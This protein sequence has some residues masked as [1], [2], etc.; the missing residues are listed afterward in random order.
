MRRVQRSSAAAVLLAAAILVGHASLPR[1]ADAQFGSLFS[2]LNL[3]DQRQEAELA[4]R[5]A[6]E[7]ESQKPLLRDPEVQ[8]YIVEIGDRLIR[9]LRRPE[10]RYRFRV[11]ADR[12]VNAFG[13][14]GGFI[15]V[16]AGLIATADTEGEVVAVLAHEIGH[17][18]QR[19]V[20]KQ[21]S[22]QTVFQNLARLAIGQNAGQWINLAAGLGVTTGQAY[23][24]RE[25]EREADSVMVS[26]M[27]AAGYDPREA[28]AMFAKLRSIQ[29]SNPNLVSSI[30]SSHPPTSERSENVRRE[31]AK[32]SR[33]R[34]LTRDS[35]AF[36]NIRARIVAAMGRRR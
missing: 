9:S 12:A 35:R 16:N 2:N 17:Q 26:L 11:V 7:V 6:R 31:I 27:P 36:Q 10:F 28:L 29:G 18:V 23:F 25:A 5:L 14:G 3:V 22:R 24:G 13:I 21:I 8:E 30:F 34:N 15:Y 1:R 33:R 19:H 32:V 4:S 20:A